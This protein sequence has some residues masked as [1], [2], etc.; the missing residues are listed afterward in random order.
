MPSMLTKKQENKGYQVEPAGDYVL[1]WHHK[2]QIGLLLKTPDIAER[3][4]AL[5]E[6][7]HQEFESAIAG[8]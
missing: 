7:H 3:V 1:I 6:K 8:S 2:N 4:R 5:V